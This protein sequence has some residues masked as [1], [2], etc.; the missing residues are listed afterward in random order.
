MTELE[1]EPD[2]ALDPVLQLQYT[3][4]G[5][6]V[7]WLQQLKLDAYAASLC[8]EGYDDIIHLCYL[9]EEEIDEVMQDVHMKKVR[10][11]SM[12]IRF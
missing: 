4:R 6:I 7:D 9:N 1:S 11:I 8:D 2:P 12:L 5:P 10:F 3:A